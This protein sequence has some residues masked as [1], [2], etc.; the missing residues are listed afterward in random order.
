VLKKAFFGSK[1]LAL[2]CGHQEEMRGKCMGK[3]ETEKWAVR[4]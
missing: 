3:P 2:A 1:Q 4:N